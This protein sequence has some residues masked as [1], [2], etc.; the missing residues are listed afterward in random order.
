M[1][2]ER[3]SRRTSGKAKVS[4]RCFVGNQRFASSRNDA[5]VARRNLSIASDASPG[6]LANVRFPR[7]PPLTRLTAPLF[8]AWG[9]IAPERAAMVPVELVFGG[10]QVRG[11]QI[12]RA[13]GFPP[14]DGFN[15]AYRI[16]IFRLSSLAAF[17]RLPHSGDSSM[18]NEIVIQTRNLTKI[19]CDFGRKRSGP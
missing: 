17:L 5:E 9:I 10:K 8:E 15:P 2:D 7:K 1:Q 11:V 6:A 13:G 18:A 3:S 14:T 4:G 19:Y 12:R 16:G